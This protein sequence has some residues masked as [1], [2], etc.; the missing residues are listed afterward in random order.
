MTR[1]HDQLISVVRALLSIVKY[2]VCTQHIQPDTMS[3]ICVN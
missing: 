2:V 3:F 1:K